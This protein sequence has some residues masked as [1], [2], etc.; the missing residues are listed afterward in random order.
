MKEQLNFQEGYTYHIFNRGNNYEKIFFEEMNYYYFLDL[1]KKY[2]LPVCEIYA[3]CLIPNHFHI[4]LKLNEK[5]ELPEDYRNGKRKLHQPFSNFFNA[6]SKAINKK[7]NRRG[8]LFQDHLT[9]NVIDIDDCF[10]NAVLYIHLNPNHHNLNK[11]Y[12][13][14]IFSSYRDYVKNRPGFLEKE[15]VLEQFGNIENFIFLHRKR[16]SDLTGLQDLLGLYDT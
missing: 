13:D 12:P 8:S 14:Y 15:Y 5:D 9:R 1:T 4:L 16:L 7:Y 6:Y 11:S 10:I 3:Y 2:L